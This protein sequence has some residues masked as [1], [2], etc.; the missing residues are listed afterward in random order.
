MMAW[1]IDSSSIL[2]ASTHLAAIHWRGIG[3]GPAEEDC[4]KRQDHE[5]GADAQVGIG[6]GKYLV[7]LEMN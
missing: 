5:P 7:M 6:S 1:S 3:A 2:K 4:K